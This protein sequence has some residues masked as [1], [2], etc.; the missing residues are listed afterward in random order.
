[1]DLTDYRAE[2][3]TFL[4]AVDGE[5]YRHYSGQQ[6]DFDVEPIYKRHEAL[7]SRAAVDALRGGE[8]GSR[9][10]LEFAVHGL[11]G[12]ATTAETAELARREASL[13][14]EANGERMPFRQARIAQAN[15]RDPDRRAA[16]EAASLHITGRELQPLLLAL[17]E[18]TGALVG[19]LGWP[20]VLALVEDLSGIDLG[21][22]GTQTDAFLTGTDGTYEAVVEPELSAQLG[23]GFA[24]LRRSDLPAFFRAPGLD[25]LFPVAERDR[26]FGETIAGLGLDASAGQNVRVDAEARPKKS[27]RA[28]CAPVRVPDEV[29]LVIA[30]TGGRDDYEALLH[31]AGHAYHYGHVDRALAFEQRYLGDNSVTE[32]F[33]FLFQGLSSDP[34]WLRRRLGVEDPSRVTAYA[35]ASK[36][37]F[38]RRYCAKLAYELELHAEG[39]DLARM[40]GEYAQ[41]LSGAVRVDWPAVTWL[42]DVDA[43]FYAARYLRAWAFETHLRALL[44][45]RF[46]PAWFEQRAAGDELKSLMREGQRRP[47]HELLAELRG[48]ELDFSAL[49]ADVAG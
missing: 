45:E 33:A 20:S 48:E 30:P 37:I 47:A 49:L 39:A 21:A 4:T 16:I 25:E 38:L 35:R 46:G 32:G 34:E 5:Y 23:I 28:F 8:D 1:M 40:P 27:P 18:R 22:L 6:E 44:A 17:H 11:I 12:R 31:E 41:R 3:E 43:F 10:L 29:Y 14:L 24:D 42:A 9:E 15:E 26:V 2:A 36:L 7:F 13:E 19:D